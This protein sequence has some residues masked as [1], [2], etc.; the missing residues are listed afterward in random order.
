[1]AQMEM[2]EYRESEYSQRGQ[3][4][5]ASDV[6]NKKAD[7]KRYTLKDRIYWVELIFRLTG[8][9]KLTNSLSINI[10]HRLLFTG[11]A[12]YAHTYLNE[13]RI[14]SK[15][16]MTSFERS[17]ETDITRHF[18]MVV[19]PNI[20][21]YLD[22]I[23][24]F[25]PGVL[26]YHYFDLIM[27]KSDGDISTLHLAEHN[28]N[29]GAF[30]KF[31]SSLKEF[32]R[33]HGYFVCIWVSYMYSRFHICC[34]LEKKSFLV[35]LSVT[36]ETHIINCNFIAV[37][38][39]TYRI[40]LSMADRIA[41]LI[42]RRNVVPITVILDTA[43]QIRD[44]L[45]LLRKQTNLTFVVSYV[46]ILSI[47]LR[48]GY[49]MI[50]AVRTGRPVFGMLLLYFL[51]TAILLMAITGYNRIHRASRL[52]LDLIESDYYLSLRD[53][54]SGQTDDNHILTN[55]NR[56]NELKEL[57]RKNEILLLRRLVGEICG[58]WPTN[59]LT[60]DIKHVIS[61]NILIMTI[62]ISI[63]QLSSYVER[64][65]IHRSSTNHTYHS[66]HW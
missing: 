22:N 44:A 60:P 58:I 18:F 10:V 32:I 47:I 55:N 1:M 36:P 65:D 35:F 59:W 61:L 8:S 51:P 13:K 42:E 27:K 56:P 9:L 2:R 3:V 66:H 50:E 17:K 21:T 54:C 34:V 23:V 14:P 28:T 52:L 30:G 31:I 62:I 57:V 7:G 49:T 5:A 6:R 12:L 40:T 20:C 15:L 41:L 26:N 33:D 45:L 63:I 39:I 19:V 37:F 25:F 53:S 16:L 38:Y 48:R 24:T 43:I 4:S 11:Y 46:Y 64:F 29:R